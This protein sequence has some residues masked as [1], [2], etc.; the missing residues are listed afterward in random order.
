MT[1]APKKKTLIS[2]EAIDLKVREMGAQITADYPDKDRKLIVISVLKGA[3][4]FTADLIREI[5]RPVVLEVL[6]AGSYGAKTESSGKVNLKYFSFDTLEGADVLLVDD[7]TDTGRTLLAIGELLKK[8]YNPSSLKYCTFLDK[9]AR[10]V[11]DLKA[12]YIGYEI[13]D[14]F[15]VGYGLDFAEDYRDLPEIAII[16]P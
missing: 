5:K 2:K 7:I 11:V 9:P 8:E 15:V 16:E 3:M 1:T 13:P 6:I 12:D 14:E 10:R 4:V